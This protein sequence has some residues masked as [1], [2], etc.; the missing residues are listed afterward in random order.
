MIP[1]RL[2]RGSGLP[3]R[4]STGK[5]WS[6]WLVALATLLLAGCGDSDSGSNAS[7]QTCREDAL[8][9]TVQTF[10][11]GVGPSEGIAFLD[12]TLYI[13]GGRGVRRLAPDGTATPLGSVPGSI[14]MVAW[15]GDLYIASQSVGG[16]SVFCGPGNQGAIW[17]M[18]TSGESSIFARGFNSPNF[19][20]V[21]P[22]GTLLV[23][24]DC[25]TNKTMYEVSAEGAVSVW[26]TD[27]TSANGM[28]FTPTYDSLFVV[29][30]FVR[31]PALHKIPITTGHTAGTVSVFKN[32]PTGSTPDGMAVDA[33]GS[34]YVA[35]NILGTVRKVAPDGTESDFATGL[36]TPASFAFGNG[37]DYDPCSMYVTSLT[38][39]D[40][41]RVVVGKPGNPLI[42]D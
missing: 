34:A 19:V 16:P 35:L 23:A 9:G 24:D 12:G 21:T 15:K 4:S 13:S 1:S 10:A 20:V 39:D 33:E 3:L 14:G 11:A 17:K 8:P 31:Q 7:P 29:N 25:L 42:V 40:V 28:G 18:T 37:P 2:L 36:T 6:P 5:R 26:T 41:S 27:I 30:T 22:W 38:G 32:L